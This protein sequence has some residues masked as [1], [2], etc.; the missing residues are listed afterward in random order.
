MEEDEA[1]RMCCWTLRVGG[2][3]LGGWEEDGP[4][5]S[6]VQRRMSRQRRG[7]WWGGN[8]ARRRRRLRCRAASLG[9]RS[10]DKVGGWVGGW[11]GGLDDEWIE[12]VGGRGQRWALCMGREVGGLLPTCM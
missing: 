3:V 4:S 5:T 2:W 8:S 11:V 10:L 1:V 7:L 9:I 6:L 12:W